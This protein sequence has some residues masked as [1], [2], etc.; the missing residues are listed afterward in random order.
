MKGSKVCQTSLHLSNN[1]T[2]VTGV[3]RKLTLNCTHKTLARYHG[4]LQ[5]LNLNYEDLFGNERVL[6]CTFP[7]ISKVVLILLCVHSLSTAVI[8]ACRPIQHAA[9]GRG[10]KKFTLAPGILVL[11]LL[12]VCLILLL[13]FEGLQFLNGIKNL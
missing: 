8:K 4:C 6:F 2:C 11:P 13:T 3:D 9:S 12:P 7:E 1:L 10:I 5:V